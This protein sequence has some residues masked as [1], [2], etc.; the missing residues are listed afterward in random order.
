MGTIVINQTDSK[1]NVVLESS[2]DG[3]TGGYYDAAGVWHDLGGYTPENQVYIG[4]KF[5]AKTDRE[6]IE[7]T[8]N[9]PAVATLEGG[10][11]AIEGYMA[12]YLILKGTNKN[13]SMYC[14]DSNGGLHDTGIVN[15]SGSYNSGYSNLVLTLLAGIPEWAKEK[16]DIGF[17]E[18]EE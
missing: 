5:K 11:A 12:A 18:V 7:T 1:Q 17:E 8:F 4:K 9:I 13:V 2:L 16:F 3:V 6:I 15:N 10:P 14:V